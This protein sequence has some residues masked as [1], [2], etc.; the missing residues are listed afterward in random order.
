M[1]CVRMNIVISGSLNRVRKRVKSSGWIKFSTY[2]PFLRFEYKIIFHC[3]F[4]EIGFSCTLVSIV[5]IIWM[6]NCFFLFWWSALRILK[7]YSFLRQ[8][9]GNLLI[10]VNKL[11]SV[12]CNW[13]QLKF[14]IKATFKLILGKQKQ[15]EFLVGSE[16]R[17]TDV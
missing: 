1:I 4:D 9:N 11:F 15:E 16:N 3:A 7:L 10:S 2:I 14:Q 8:T 17:T 13:N 5:L 6:C 12:I